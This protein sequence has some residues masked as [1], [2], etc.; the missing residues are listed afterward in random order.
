MGPHAAWL[1]SGSCTLVRLLQG[2]YVHATFCSFVPTLS[3]SAVRAYSSRQ[4]LT[5]QA[6]MTCRTKLQLGAH[7]LH[8][9]IMSLC[10]SQGDHAVGCCCASSALCIT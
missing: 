3:N 5:H 7:V 6:Y 9:V 2:S 10:A 1:L 8:R 4:S